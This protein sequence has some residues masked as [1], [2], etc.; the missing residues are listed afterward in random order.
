[1]NTMVIFSCSIL[2]TDLAH[3]YVTAFPAMFIPVFSDNIKNARKVLFCLCVANLETVWETP[4][5]K[6]PIQDRSSRYFY[7]NAG[8]LRSKGH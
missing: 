6:V 5:L 2:Y 1:M 7:S 3:V 4:L 8:W